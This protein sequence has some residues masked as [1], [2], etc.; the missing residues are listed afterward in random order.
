MWGWLNERAEQTLV[1]PSQRLAEQGVVI[2][3]TAL[4][5]QLNK[6]GLVFKKTLH[7]S[8]QERADV[9]AARAQ[10]RESQSALKV[11]KLVF[12]DETAAGTNMTRAR[13]RSPKGQ[14]CVAAVSHGHWHT[15]TFIAGLR[16]NALAAPMV[17]EGP[18][19]GGA[20]R[21]LATGSGSLLERKPVQFINAIST[22]VEFIAFLNLWRAVTRSGSCI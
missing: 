11:N 9:Q 20:C 1:E 19:D 12:L 3:T 4:W 2:K 10:W 18:M 17:L 14:G 22:N 15:T 7:A 16:V 13:G 6:W 8:E 21:S 5:H